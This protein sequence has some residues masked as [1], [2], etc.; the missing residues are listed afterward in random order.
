MKGRGI[1]TRENEKSKHRIGLSSFYMQE[2]ANIWNYL[3][4]SATKFKTLFLS[5]N[6][7]LVTPHK[8]K[9]DLEAKMEKRP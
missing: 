7:F 3:V 1:K 4:L 5:C 8:E 2:K 9:T 6:C